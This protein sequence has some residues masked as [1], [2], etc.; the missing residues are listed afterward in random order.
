MAAQIGGNVVNVLV[1]VDAQQGFV[2]LQR[3]VHVDVRAL[4]VS[5]ERPCRPVGLH[6]DH[7][8]LV[9]A[10]ETPFERLTGSKRNGGGRRPQG[11]ACRRVS[12]E[13]ASA[14]HQP[15]LLQRARVR[16][17]GRHSFEV[18]GDRVTR[19]ALRSE[20]GLP[21]GGVAGHD[22][23]RPDP[24][25]IAAVDRETVKEGGDIGN[26]AGSEVKLGHPR[27]TSVLDD[28]RDDFPVLIVLHELRPEQARAAV[29]TP[30]V[31][32]VAKLAVDTVEGF[33]TLEDRRIGRRT[34]RIGAATAAGCAT[35]S[36]AARRGRLLGAQGKS[37]HHEGH[38]RPCDSVRARHATPPHSIRR[39][40]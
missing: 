20:V 38:R 26:L 12:A 33:P 27:W 35:P 25:R 8:E 29:T 19:G 11:G 39:G 1:G 23:F 32:A 28:R 21:R 36:S 30:R 24:C 10:H 3:I 14:R 4:A 37:G 7:G 40:A 34:L 2:R 17:S 5:T 6:H 9:D 13:S 15:P 22:A 31:S 16:K 18:P